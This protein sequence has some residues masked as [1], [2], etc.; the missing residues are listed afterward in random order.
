MTIKFTCAECAASYD[1]ADDLA[2]KTIRCRECHGFN[3]A[4][5]APPK[6]PTSTA[7]VSIPNLRR[8]PFF[9][10]TKGLLAG[11]VLMGLAG[12]VGLWFG[13]ASPKKESIPPQSSSLPSMRSQSALTPSPTVGFVPDRQ[14]ASQAQREAALAERQ[15]QAWLENQREQQT[16]EKATQEQVRRQLEEEQR[17]RQ[18]QTVQ[19]LLAQW[20]QLQR[21]KAAEEDY[22][23]RVERECALMNKWDQQTTL[24]IARKLHAGQSIGLREFH[25]M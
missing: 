18:A 4:P 25:F 15:R 23:R 2:G 21:E 7:P 14:A 24:N 5:F 3:R 1:V 9:T 11:A 17:Q 19:E 6:Q 10:F 13:L 12:A 16:R 22:Q 20:Q 8:A